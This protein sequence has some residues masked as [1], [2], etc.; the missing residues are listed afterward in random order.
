[1]VDKQ[2][3][4]YRGDDG[5][6]A[7]YKLEDLGGMLGINYAGDD[8]T[9]YYYINEHGYISVVT[10]E[11]ELIKKGYVL[12]PNNPPKIF[13]KSRK[14]HSFNKKCIEALETLGGISVYNFDNED[15]SCPD[16][17][18][19][20]IEENGIINWGLIEKCPGYKELI[21]PEVV[22][23]PNKPCYFITNEADLQEVAKYLKS[24]GGNDLIGYATRSMPFDTVL[25]IYIDSLNNIVTS[26]HIPWGHTL[27]AFPKDVTLTKICYVVNDIESLRK[28]FKHLKS[29]GGL[30]RYDYADKNWIIKSDTYVFLKEDKTIS[31]SINPPK[32]YTPLKLSSIVNDGAVISMDF[33][34]QGILS[35]KPSV[36][37][38]SEGMGDKRIR[39][40]YKV[41]NEQTAIWIKER[42]ERLGANIFRGIMH[43]S[44]L[45]YVNNYNNIVTDITETKKY[46]KIENVYK[47]IYFIGINKYALE[48]LYNLTGE[49]TT[50][51]N[52]KNAQYN[53][54]F[55]V[56]IDPVDGHVC[57]ADLTSA[58]IESLQDIG[59]VEAFPKIYIENKDELWGDSIPMSEY[60]GNIGN[61]DNPATDYIYLNNYGKLEGTNDLNYLKSMN[62]KEYVAENL[63]N[64]EVNK[65]K[66]I[67]TM[68]KGLFS[69]LSEKFRA[70]YVPTK[71][72]GLKL[73]HTGLICIPVNGEYVG[74]D[75]DNNLTSFDAALTWDYPVYTISKPSA[76]VQIGDIIKQGESFGKVIAKKADGSF[77]VLSFTGST[78]NKKIIKDFILG[79]AVV[80]TVV[81]MF[82]DI[83]NGNINP[84]MMMMMMGED[85]DFEMKDLMMLQMMQ[86]GA[87]GNAMNPMML[88]MM[89]DKN[90][91]SGDKSSMMENLMMMQMMQGNTTANPFGSMFGG[92]TPTV[93]PEVKAE[94]E[95]DSE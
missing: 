32:G 82:G 15:I 58:L 75:K 57:I 8:P 28:V 79:S 68:K 50:D 70:Q 76:Q 9:C 30:D 23:M 52:I 29:L 39:E 88:M 93:V 62:Y 36:I 12:G 21:I 55:I 42:L 14:E 5:D 53:P 90:G 67:N 51:L 77:S 87:N 20:F 48:E 1:M 18:C 86:G 17:C 49:D 65:S 47:K 89:M 92:Q 80:T 81:N 66:K 34:T 4:Y 35:H 59:Y 73:S 27:S 60:S 38:L 54:N 91:E 26:K 16:K 95:V 2:K 13:Y 85:S 25:Y 19:Y 61:V 74:I 46:S 7:I 84:M 72:N 37:K 22:P 11:E 69:G 40:C 24:T 33:K 10:N 63:Q 44:D 45:V 31:L 56:Y 43:P 3:I 41:V 71:E 83:S 64:V 78:R 6:P 94:T